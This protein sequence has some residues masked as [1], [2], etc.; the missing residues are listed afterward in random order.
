MAAVQRTGKVCEAAVCYTGDIDDPR[1]D[2][3]PL[4]YYVRMAQELERMGAHTLAIKDMAGLLKPYAA[5]RL[6]KA[7]KNEIG[8][9]VHFHTHD[10]SGIAA[11]SILKACDAGVDVADA[12]ISSMS[13]STSQPNLNSIVAA[14][15]H[16]H[17][18]ATGLDFEALNRC[19]DYWETVRL[20]YAP[21]DT[22]PRSGMADVYIHEMPGGQYTNLR[23]QAESLGLGHHWPEIA[24]MYADVN[25]AFGDIVKV[26]PSSKVVGDLALF[27]IQ[28]G[29]TVHEFER[30]PPDHSLNIPN[31]VV[32]MFEGAL[33]EPEGG[34][35]K[36]IASVILRGGK[37]KRGRA[38]ARLA[39]IDFD[40]TRA[41]IEKKTG[42]KPGETEL[43]SYVMYP[44][45]FVKFAKARASYG[46]LSGLP[47]PVF[48]YGMQ[49]DQE[50]AVDLEPGKTLVVKF[51]AVGEPHQD[52]TRTVFF[53][54]NGQPR[55]VNI[56]D[57]KL[58]VETRANPKADPLQAG[59]VG[60]PIPG[61]VTSIAVELNQEVKKGDKLL[62]IE[63]MKMQTTIYAPINGR[64]AVRSVHVGQTVEPKDLLIAIGEPK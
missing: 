18:R 27:L 9:P 6:V 60:A 26:T 55:E 58:K 13:G 5:Q 63:A 47:S 56:R 21:F 10:T 25:R 4:Q 23:E 33:G 35:P 30:L 42:H 8:L 17:V 53:E 16:D 24:R 64:V 2:K 22:A 61:A 1:R 46:D 20:N 11:A 3:Y 57:R 45:V 62:V 41:V 59:H 37:P 43:M 50:M 36:Q 52:G 44:D 28:H 48:F 31:S 19:S 32:E 39:P 14:L 12:A 49:K 54:L 15:Q 40:A 34:W 7:L 38:G 29:M 51:L